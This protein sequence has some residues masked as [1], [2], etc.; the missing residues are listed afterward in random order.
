MK[1]AGEPTE[2]R[3]QDLE[4][5]KMLLGFWQ[6]PARTPQDI[7]YKKALI[8]ESSFDT[9]EFKRIVTPQDHFNRT[10]LKPISTIPA[11][12]GKDITMRR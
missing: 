12:I 9:L 4:N 11:D 3:S 10:T 7:Y 1:G 8:F 6:S 5:G 2:S